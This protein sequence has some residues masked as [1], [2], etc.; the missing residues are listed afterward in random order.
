MKS[1]R[2]WLLILLT[3]LLPLRA[4]AAAAMLCTPAPVVAMDH[5]AHAYPHAGHHGQAMDHGD[6]AHPAADMQKCTLCCAF[7]TGAPMAAPQPSVPQ[8]LAVSDVAFPDLRA[9]A[10]SFL[11]DGQDR[12]PRS[13]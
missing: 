2:I 9:P 3:A 12:P 7:G 4:V 10:P 5:T 11:S 8:P 1:A 13:S 6:P